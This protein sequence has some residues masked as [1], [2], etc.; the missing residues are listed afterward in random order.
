MG[1]ERYNSLCQTCFNFN[2]NWHKY[3]TPV[4]GWEAT[5][6]LIEDGEPMPMES[7]EVKSCPKYIARKETCHKIEIAELAKKTHLTR[8]K[9]YRCLLDGTYKKVFP[10]KVLECLIYDIHDKN[11]IIYE[12]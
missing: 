4:K 2:C 3:F 12:E 5:P 6:T 10:K 7:Y 8:A 1:K 9:C 11:F